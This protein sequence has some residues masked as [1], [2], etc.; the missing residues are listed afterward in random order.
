[1]YIAVYSSGPMVVLQ[2]LDAQGVLGERSLITAADLAAAVAEREPQHPRWVWDDT[3]RWYP[4]LLAAQVRVE[5]CVDLRLSHAILRRSSLT[6]ESTLAT[7]AT[8]SWDSGALPAAFATAERASAQQT[9]FDFD[10]ARSAALP[11]HEPGAD[12][13]HSNTSAQL[14]LHLQAEDTLAE[15]ERQR[16]AVASA[17]NP[18]RIGLLLA[19]E[20]AGALIAAEM[21]AAGLPWSEDVHDGILRCALGPRPTTGHRPALLEAKLA[22]LRTAL[23]APTLNPDSPAEL[24]RA[25]MVAGLMVKSTRSGELRTLTHPAIEPLL[26]Y[27]KLARLFSA[28]G[29]NWLDANVSAGRFHPE[30]VPGGVVTG[31]WSSAGGG[32]AL[33]LPKHIRS[34]VVADAGWQ[35]VVADAAQLEPRILAAL[36]GDR[37]MAEAGTDR[38]LYAGIVSSGAVETRDQAKVAMLGAMYGATSGES[39]R[40]MPRLARA[41]PQAIALVE[42]AAR[43]GELGESVTTRLGRSSPKPGHP[44]RHELAQG[45]AQSYDETATDADANRAR[46]AAR[47]WGRFTRNFVVQGSAAEW[48]LCWMASL[49]RAL[50]ELN[51]GQWLTESA[52]LVFFMHDE[53]V[54]HCP[55]AMVAPVERAVRQAAVEA[56]RLMFGDA[57]VTFPLTIA[58]V[59]NYG[60]AK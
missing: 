29:W 31:R 22:E 23:N 48:A 44:W 21:K 12:A 49:R 55:A 27:K 13:S 43:A 16:E 33:Q 35:L 11:P 2:C 58:V 37:N 50:H 60:Q 38:D 51:A 46:T 1:M 18:A 14:P 53:V 20:S 59:D 47:S 26:R 24:L 30:Y 19:A 52:H 36:S 3:T 56:G 15:F 7:A 32:G 8:S 25:L 41:F 42:A 17:V 9:L 54:V 39:G 45:P 6:S 4:A 10:D 28:S 57:P 34:A 5:R 40:L